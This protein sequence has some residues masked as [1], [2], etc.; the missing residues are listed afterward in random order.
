MISEIIA[1]I[2]TEQNG[3]SAERT[4][5][6]KYKHLFRDLRLKAPSFDAYGSDV[7]INDLTKARIE[8]ESLNEQV[9]GRYH[10]FGLI[11]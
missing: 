8:A 5:F 10:M 4:S 7:G 9:R 6:I 1:R 11:N 2:Q 3:L